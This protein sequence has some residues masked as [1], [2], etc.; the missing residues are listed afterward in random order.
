[1]QTFLFYVMQLNNTDKIYSMLKCFIETAKILD[2]KRLGKQRVEASQLINIIENKIKL[3]DDYEDRIQAKKIVSEF[4]DKPDK[5]PYKIEFEKF[6]KRLKRVGFR[7]HPAVKQWTPYVESLKLYFNVMVKQWVL[8]GYN[9]NYSPYKI[10]EKNLVVPPFLYNE[11]FIEYQRRNMIRKDQGYYSKHFGKEL[12]PF[13]GY[14]W[15]I[16]KDQYKL[17]KTKTSTVSRKRK[18]IKKTTKSKKIKLR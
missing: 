13:S 8:K 16:E 12:E 14:Y 10:N 2:P 17:I 6:K 3:D 1:M 15:F 9:N 5:W 7:N 11:K 18:S 4:E